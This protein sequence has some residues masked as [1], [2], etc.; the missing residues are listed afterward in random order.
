ML[1]DPIVLCLPD[2]HHLLEQASPRGQIRLSELAAEPW[3]VV[4]QG[5][6]ARDQFDRAAAE[7]GFVPRIQAETDS[8]A[9]AQALVGA[10]LG[11]AAISRL[12]ARATSGVVHVALGQPRLS[13][14]IFAVTRLRDA[15]L[16]AASHEFID[17]LRKAADELEWPGQASA[18]R[19]LPARGRH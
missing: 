12:A 17:L 9:A 7:A 16:N 6:P 2:G 14:R 10:G 1:T 3:I 15:G 4:S 11:I 13:R 19:E 18:D 8:Y 5:I